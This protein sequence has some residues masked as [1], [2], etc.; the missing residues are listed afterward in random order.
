[1]GSPNDGR[2]HDQH[3]CRCFSVG[4][5]MISPLRKMLAGLGF[6]PQNAEMPHG[7]VWGLRRRM[8]EYKQIHIKAMP[9]QL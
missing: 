4:A 7:Q 2:S 9:G 1:M 8:S 3:H 6:E 5:G